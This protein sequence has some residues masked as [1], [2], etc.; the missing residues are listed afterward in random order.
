MQLHLELW[1]SDFRW[2]WIKYVKGF[3]P[4]YHCERCLLGHRSSRFSY[5]RNEQ[6]F[7]W[8]VD[9]PLDEW[10]APFV[11]ICGVTSV[12]ERNFHLALRAA[13]GQAITLM[14]SRFRLH[15]SNA[16]SVPIYPVAGDVPLEF[17]RC[18]NFQF[19]YHYLLNTWP[20]PR[21]RTVCTP[22]QF[23]VLSAATPI[24]GHQVAQRPAFGPPLPNSMR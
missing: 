4:R 2:L 14:D 15:V 24:H 20:K 6:Q 16:E 11:Y 3:N 19:G 22:C 12:Y 9:F 10:E 17:A 8:R 7:P 18:R 5:R 1:S 13:A 21:E 23:D